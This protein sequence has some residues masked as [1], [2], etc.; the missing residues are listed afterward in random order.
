MARTSSSRGRSPQPPALEKPPTE[1]KPSN[2]PKPKKAKKV[3]SYKSEG[4]EDNDVFL[5]PVRDYW[6]VLGLTVLATA[7][8]VWK[9][10]QPSSVV[11]DEVQ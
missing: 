11:F 4:V 5:L 9:I 3:A 1:R 8:R 7:V 6:V 10:S 2:K